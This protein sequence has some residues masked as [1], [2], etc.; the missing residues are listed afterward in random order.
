MIA[1]T[2]V[3]ALVPARAG[4]KGIPRK[5]LQLLGDRSLLRWAVDFAIEAPDI[6]AC[7][8]STDGA[9]IA[10]EALRLGAR[11][12][13]R[14]PYLAD[15]RALVIDTIRD[16]VAD[17]AMGLRGAI[18]VLLEPTS[19]FRRHDDLVEC[20]Q[21][22]VAGADS[23]ATFSEAELHPHRAFRI[24]SA[25]A[26]PY[27]D[28]AVPWRP[29]QSL[30]PPAYQ[31]TGALYAFWVDRLPRDGVSVL[32]GDIYAAAVPRGNSIDID[33]VHDLEMA[34]A[35]LRRNRVHLTP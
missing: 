19:P 2:R 14:P 25:R 11:V 1:A 23:A 30:T 12:R 7:V 26:V 5:N 32:F 16:V 13:K 24:E 21:A 15:D 9:E 22:L 28:G 29:R 17:R 3:I 34:N 27:I 8:V 4:S 18:C 20:L 33:D 35:V 6:D 10:D 31:L